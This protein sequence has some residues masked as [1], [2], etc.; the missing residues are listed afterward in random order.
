MFSPVDRVIRSERLRILRL[1]AANVSNPLW[2][3]F[4]RTHLVHSAYTLRL[5]DGLSIE[6]RP[7]SGDWWA[8][9]EI[10]LRR[11]YSRSGQVFRQG[12]T[13]VDVGANIGCF[14]LLAAQAVGQSGRVIA[15]EPEENTFRQLVRNIELNGLRNI[16]PLKAAIG[17]RERTGTIHVDTNK[18]FT[19]LFK[20]VDGR[21][22]E[23]EQQSTPM[24]TLQNLFRQQA[25]EDCDYL[26]LDCE[27]AEYE[28]IEAMSPELA[29]RVQQI[30][31]EVHD[32]PGADRDQLNTRLLALGYE[33]IASDELSY[34][35][36]QSSRADVDLLDLEG[37]RQ[38]T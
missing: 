34:Y 26:K 4:D 24:T 36:R 37:S 7:H 19:S 25:I 2:V 33:R 13:V 10:M 6:L 28:I 12:S 9:Y 27:G 17:G 14:S 22:I 11:D 16:T 5:K 23:G 3:I 18:L 29:Q 32:I 30:T 15:I 31:M 20:E 1:L 35:R 8:L 38:R 21:L